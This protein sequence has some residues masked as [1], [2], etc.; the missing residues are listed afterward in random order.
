[1]CIVQELCDSWGGRPRLSILTSL[2]AS[3]DKVLLCVCACVRFFFLLLLFV[4]LYIFLHLTAMYS[5]TFGNGWVGRSCLYLLVRVFFG[6]FSLQE[7]TCVHCV[8]QVL[9]TCKVLCG[10]C[11]CAIYKF[12]FIHSLNHA[13]A[14]V[15][16]CPCLPHPRTLSI[17]SS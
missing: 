12:S 4:T 8:Y 17:T 3:A 6:S 7:L 2:L 9:W 13:L 5:S 16:A 14:L 10:S 15:S 1:M 11:L